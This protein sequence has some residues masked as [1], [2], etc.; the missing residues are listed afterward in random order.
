MEGFTDCQKQRAKAARD[1]YHQVA[2]PTLQN[3]KN[4]IGQNLFKNCP[5]TVADCNLAE[6]IYDPDIATLKGQSVHS[7]GTK[8]VEEYIEIPADF[9]LN[10][11]NGIS[12]NID[13]MYINSQPF[14]SA[15]DDVIKFRSLVPMNNRTLKEL[16]AS[17]DAILRLYN[18]NG[19]KKW[20]KTFVKII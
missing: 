17:L 4:A 2:A 13:V 11:A 8:Q 15:I 6:K 14:M 12:L 7:K 10:H 5:I 9:Q 1:F 20:F 16:F 18:K 19:F 3:L